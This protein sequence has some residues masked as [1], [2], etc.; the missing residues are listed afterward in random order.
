VV[1]H[2]ET[3]VSWPNVSCWSFRLSAVESASLFSPRGERMRACCWLSKWLCYV[4]REG[5]RRYEPPK[6]QRL[7]ARFRQPFTAETLA[8]RALSARRDNPRCTESHQK[9]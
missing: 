8:F 6:T 3:Y 5:K 4:V 1:K 9:D 7:P 2:L